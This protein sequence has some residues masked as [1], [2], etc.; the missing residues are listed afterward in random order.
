MMWGIQHGR[1]TSN[2]REY[3]LAL[4][5]PRWLATERFVARNCE[6]WRAK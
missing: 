1:R 4:A 2:G 6:S 3:L 5:D